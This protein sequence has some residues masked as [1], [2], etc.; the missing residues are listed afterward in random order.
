VETQR[1]RLTQQLG[2]KGLAALRSHV[3]KL[4][5]AEGAWKSRD[6]TST[7]IAY[8]R[9]KG[10]L[11]THQARWYR[12]HPWRWQLKLL[13]FGARYLVLQLVGLVAALVRQ[14]LNLKLAK[15]IRR[16]R[17]FLLS[18]RYRQL[19]ARRYALWR[20]RA[21]TR[22]QFILSA[23]ARRLQSEL[24]SDQASVCV[25]D[26]GV[27]LSI[28][29]AVKFLQWWIFPLLFALGVIHLPAL[30]FLE[31]FGGAIGRTAYTLY[32]CAE[33]SI[34]RRRRP[35]VAL[36]VGGLPVLGN[37]AYPLQFVYWCAD[38][39]RRLA[40]FLLYDCFATLGRAMPIW[41]GENSLLEA[42]ANRLP[43]LFLRRR[44]GQ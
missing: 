43:D 42:W 6:R 44:T 3:D 17:R 10:R 27:H 18:S 8:F 29:P 24:R 33:S 37:V 15:W 30:V 26:F 22:R 16:V 34:Q 31:V 11:S 19:L 7:S 21:W 36:A 20:M 35:W 1:E 2:A 39:R 28:K 25:T 5:R 12:Q 40:Q 38:R 32:R 14:C 41:G 4:A 13:G 9:R 23:D